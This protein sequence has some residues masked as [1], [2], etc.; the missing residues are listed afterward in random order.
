MVRVITKRIEGT[1]E[2]FPKTHGLVQ[3]RDGSLMVF[4]CVIGETADKYFDL[5]KNCRD[6]GLEESNRL[7]DYLKEIGVKAVRGERMRRRNSGSNKEE[8][9]DE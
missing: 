1:N 6:G 4:N 2:A 8:G 3:M 5:F 7:L 9:I